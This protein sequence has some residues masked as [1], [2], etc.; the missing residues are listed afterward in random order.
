MRPGESPRAIHPP[1]GRGRIAERRAWHR[2]SRTRAS[3][4][5][6]SSTASS[7]G[8]SA[9]KT[10]SSA[11]RRAAASATVPISQAG[12]TRRPFA[13]RSP[14]LLLPPLRRHRWRRQ[15]LGAAP[16][17]ARAPRR[18]AARGRV[19]CI[20][21]VVAS[22]NRA[23]A[24]LCRDL[25]RA[26]VPTNI[27]RRRRAAASSLPQRLP[28]T[29]PQ[30]PST[31]GRA[32]RCWSSAVSLGRAG[33]SATQMSDRN[34]VRILQME[35]YI[36]NLER[37]ILEVGFEPV[38]LERLRSS[39]VAHLIGGPEFT[40]AALNRPRAAATLPPAA[41]AQRPAPAPAAPAN[42]TPAA[43]P[44][45]ASMDTARHSSTIGFASR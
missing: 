42:P 37:F 30:R 27:S 31:T 22:A 17:D 44:A 8:A 14:A 7:L 34:D 33:P 6:T 1:R 9:Q 29:N 4:R 2:S 35:T 11:K 28:S 23:A 15:E 5:A 16:H 12:L 43:N 25:H 32:P 45:A 19:T 36:R 24:P 40:A 41:A 3:R 21:P 26:G 10:S 13:G 18:R 38:V 39:T 20:H